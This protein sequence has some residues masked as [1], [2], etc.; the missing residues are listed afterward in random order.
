LPD[1][2]T[3]KLDQINSQTAAANAFLQMALRPDD[4]AQAVASGQLQGIDGCIAKIV[5]SI[6]MINSA[7]FAD[8]NISKNIGNAFLSVTRELGNVFDELFVPI[9]F[10]E[11]DTFADSVQSYQNAIVSS[12]SS[13]F[14]AAIT[15]QQNILV[16]SLQKVTESLGYDNREG[17][18][19]VFN[20]YRDKLQNIFSSLFLNDPDLGIAGIVGF[21][22]T[23]GIPSIQ[24]EQFYLRR[25]KKAIRTGVEQV[26]R[27]PK[28]LD[29]QLPNASA[30]SQLCAAEKWL[31]TVESKLTSSNVFDRKSFGN[32]TSAVCKTKNDIYDGK[33]DKDFLAYHAGNLSG[34]SPADLKAMGLSS[35]L[36]NI[37]LQISLVELKNY[38]SAFSQEDVQTRTLYN[39]FQ[40]ILDTL[41]KLAETRLGDIMAMLVSVLRLQIS[42]L[43]AD[44]EAQAQG[45]SGMEEAKKESAE[46]LKVARET[47][48]ALAADKPVPAEA[49]TGASAKK[50]EA[51]GAQQNDIYA[52]VSSQAAAYVILTALCT[53]M[54]K[55]STIYATLDKVLAGE[56]RVV[57]FLQD[58]I[59]KLQTQC[60]G[61]QGGDEVIV[62]VK[63]YDAAIRDRLNG[64]AT[65]NEYVVRMGQN[66]IRRIEEYEKFLACFKSELFFGNKALETIVSSIG[67]AL[68]TYQTLKAIVNQIKMALRLYPQMKEMYK[69]MNLARML[70]LDAAGITA[71]DTIVAGLQCFVLQCDNPAI[72]SLATMAA[73]QFQD[74]FAKKKSNAITMKAIDED[75]KT[76]LL[77]TVVT[78]VQ[79]MMRLMQMLQRI[80]NAD[81]NDLCAVK[82]QA[83]SDTVGEANKKNES[84]I[85]ADAEN[86]RKAKAKAEAAASAQ[87]TNDMPG[88]VYRSHQ[89]YLLF[90]SDLVIDDLPGISAPQPLGSSR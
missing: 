3:D 48:E 86:K 61:S 6:P 50:G 41:S 30:V 25:M 52:Y 42:G 79:A 56:S 53:I 89:A 5:L 72:S 44:L 26:S 18:N 28:R 85:A 37:Q 71:L 24:A 45:F 68:A 63:A 43:R 33:I 51:F 31:K 19:S 58:F 49:G 90:P 4:I 13:P 76:G 23:E 1:N 22:I 55:T 2:F 15:A 62:T 54:Q 10:E 8:S 64:G 7:G 74:Q 16:S 67:Q 46:R 66:A 65:T 73:Q 36:P 27:L 82:T 84:A 12:I 83:N 35:F 75:T 11:G 70:G 38:T 87:R 69:T 17:S 34:I 60:K 47:R 39:N 88:E 20:Q 59:G 14:S 57:K 78:R 21:A 9:D 32:A 40:L 80:T 29:A 77:A 81:L